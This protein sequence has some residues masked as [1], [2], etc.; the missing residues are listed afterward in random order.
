MRKYT[1]RFYFKYVYKKLALNIQ[2][3]DV[4]DSC[5]FQGK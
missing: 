1:L 4:M 3:W 5:T 2:S